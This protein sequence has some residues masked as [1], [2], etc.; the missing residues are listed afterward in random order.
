MQ[1][2]AGEIAM[3]CYCYLIQSTTGGD[4]WIVLAEDD[5]KAIASLPAEQGPYI[6]THRTEPVESEP[7]SM[8]CH[9]TGL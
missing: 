9:P 8:K 3:Q 2:K 7:L 6:I 5:D 4:E 1:P